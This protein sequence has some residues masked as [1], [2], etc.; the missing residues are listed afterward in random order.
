M[1]RNNAIFMD[2]LA[3]TSIIWGAPLPVI[4]SHRPIAKHS[5]DSKRHLEQK[6]DALT[7]IW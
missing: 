1:Q 6:L 2:A 4:D 3:I 7:L 5:I